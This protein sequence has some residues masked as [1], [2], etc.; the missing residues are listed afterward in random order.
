MTTSYTA[1]CRAGTVKVATVGV[2]RFGPDTGKTFPS[3]QTVCAECRVPV[4]ARMIHIETRKSRG[5]RKT[6]C[7]AACLNGKRVCDCRCNG[8]CHG[9]E[10]CYCGTVP[11]P[12]GVR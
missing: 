5:G 9:A 6:E 1:C 2:I 12:E 8:R 11:E 3:S 7:G 4:T 10:R